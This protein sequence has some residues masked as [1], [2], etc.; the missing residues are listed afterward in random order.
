MGGRRCVDGS[1][2]VPVSAA[3]VILAGD[4]RPALQQRDRW[5]G[6]AEPV[7]VILAGDGRPALLLLPGQVLGSTTAL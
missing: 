2:T 1:T 5:P 3:V 6:G 4:G 7:V